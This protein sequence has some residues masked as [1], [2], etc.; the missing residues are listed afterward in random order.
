[1]RRITGYNA[2]CHRCVSSSSLPWH[3]LNVALHQHETGQQRGRKKR[4]RQLDPEGG[5]DQTAHQQGPFHSN[6]EEWLGSCSAQWMAFIMGSTSGHLKSR[7]GGVNLLCLKPK[8]I[9]MSAYS[10]HRG[11]GH[12]LCGPWAENLSLNLR[13]V[14]ASVVDRWCSNTTSCSG[15]ISVHWQFSSCIFYHSGG[16]IW[17]TSLG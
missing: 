10:E 16:F 1:M 9:T 4:L 11:V 2:A 8:Y 7:L 17:A 6:S 15:R 5:A 13:I 12:S 14:T 3:L